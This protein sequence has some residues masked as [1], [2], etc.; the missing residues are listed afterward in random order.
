MYTDDYV[1]LFEYCFI[2]FLVFYLFACLFVCLIAFFLLCNCSE[3]A[4]HNMTK[5]NLGIFGIA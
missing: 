3:V 5:N 2:L 1:F 4:D